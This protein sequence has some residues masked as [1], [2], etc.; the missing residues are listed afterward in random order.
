MKERNEKTLGSERDAR[1][2]SPSPKAGVLGL[3]APAAV[4]PPGATDFNLPAW[5]KYAACRL[6]HFASSR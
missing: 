3:R 5:R 6:R 4:S 1:V 2:A